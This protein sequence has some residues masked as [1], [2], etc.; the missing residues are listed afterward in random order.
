VIKS[1][2]QRPWSE[3]WREER[4]CCCEKAAVDVDNDWVQAG[5]EV[6]GDQDGGFDFVIGDGLVPG[7]GQR[8]IE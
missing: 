7:L 3:E 8:V 6:F 2:L 5:F 4:V 1:E